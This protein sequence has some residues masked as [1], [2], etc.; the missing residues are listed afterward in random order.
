M[1]RELTR[2]R[3]N[4][5][6]SYAT[7]AA[8]EETKPARGRRSA[9]AAEE[10]PA[11]GRRSASAAPAAA[12]ARSVSK[13]WGSYKK[14]AEA[15]KSGGFGDDFKPR[16]GETELIKI[17]DEGP[18][19]VFKEHWLERGPGKKKSFT[20]LKD[21]DGNGNCPLCDDLGDKPKARAWVN[22]V[23]M[24][25][26]PEDQEVLIWK[27]GPLI[28]DILENAARE[29]RTSP[30]NKPGL[31]WQI[32]KTTKGPKTE[33]QV[34]AV[35]QDDQFAEDWDTEPLTDEEFND[36]AAEGYDESEVYFNSVEDLE[37][38]VEELD[39]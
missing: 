26:D 19:A 34:Q 15:T 24:L 27:V 21:E 31:Y 32:N 37:A 23:D 6:T 8:E 13:G 12:P 16:T 36:F 38:I 4:R 18:F 28:G 3:G 33:Y 29:K 25:Q 2:R 10:K 5:D 30:I 17:L 1:A 11:R 7:P 39:G 9:P 20:C 22:V 14:T 35:K